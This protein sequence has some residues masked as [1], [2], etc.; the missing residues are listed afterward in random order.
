MSTDL[1]N[2]NFAL[3]ANQCHDG[4]GDEY[5]N[6]RCRYQDEIEALRKESWEVE[7]ILGKALGYPWYKDDKKNFPDATE[8]DGVCVGEHTTVTL[9]MEIAKKRGIVDRPTRY[10]VID[11]RKNAPDVGRVDPKCVEF[12]YQD[13]GR[14]LKV[15]LSDITHIEDQKA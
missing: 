11:H 12:S 10:E 8:A 4:Y 9:A 7:Q 13:D 1:E 2:E 6:H 5:G 15:F 14:T 3:A